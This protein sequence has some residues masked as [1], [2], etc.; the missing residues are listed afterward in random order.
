MQK[1]D[2]VNAL[3]AHLDDM[4]MTAT[5]AQ[6]ALTVRQAAYQSARWDAIHAPQIRILDQQPQRAK[7]VH[8]VDRLLQHLEA[9]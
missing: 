4:T 3:H 6:P 1:K 8:R 2:R 9:L 5:R 7:T